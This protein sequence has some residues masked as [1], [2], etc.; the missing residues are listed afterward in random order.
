MV[1]NL[2]ATAGEEGSIP[3]LGR[4]PGGEHGNPFQYSSLENSMDRGAWWATVHG[5]TKLDMMEAHEG[6]MI[7]G[8]PSLCTQVCH[9]SAHVCTG[10][11]NALF[12]H[13]LL[14]SQLDS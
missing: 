13:I 9:V 6:E 10:R 5:I 14:S 7:G 12:L 3:G 2:S 11:G 1:K 4:S 8:R